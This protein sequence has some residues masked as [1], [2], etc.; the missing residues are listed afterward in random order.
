MNGGPKTASTWS[1]ITPI[2]CFAFPYSNNDNEPTQEYET[3]PQGHYTDYGENNDNDGNYDDY[4]QVPEV[5]RYRED[6]QNN[7]NQ[8]YVDYSNNEPNDYR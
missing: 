5:P 2:N 3:E 8:N 7:N 6:D 4:E 1:S